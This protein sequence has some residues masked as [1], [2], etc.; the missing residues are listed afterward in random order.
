MV[1]G[2]TRKLTQTFSPVLSQIWRCVRKCEIWPDLR[3]S[4]LWRAHGFDTKRRIG[5]LKV[6]WKRQWWDYLLP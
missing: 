3:A 5:H 2:L 6:R 4:Q 1:I